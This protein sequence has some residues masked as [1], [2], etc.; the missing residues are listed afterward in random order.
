MHLKRAK[1]IITLTLLAL[2]LAETYLFIGLIL[3]PFLLGRD[4]LSTYVLFNIPI[5][6]WYKLVSVTL[7]LVLTLI[8]SYIAWLLRYL[9]KW[10]KDE[11]ALRE[12]ISQLLDEDQ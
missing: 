7:F 1:Y 5:I 3:V 12:V 6:P 2:I 11:T 10:F 4:I 8:I 9:F